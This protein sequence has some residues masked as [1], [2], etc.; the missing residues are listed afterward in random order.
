[1]LS[2]LF[3]IKRRKPLKDGSVPIFMR[4]SSHQE[5]VECSLRRST[6]PSQWVTAKG[7]VRNNTL[8]NKQLN[9]YLDQ[10]EFRI[11][12]I[13]RGLL[14]EGKQ[15]S[16]QEVMR[17]YRGVEQRRVRCCANFMKSTIPG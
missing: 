15:V 10:Q 13:E 6:M 8:V 12:D 3:F 16:V 4:V 9:E 1:M 14:A 2:I 11:Y 17:Q 5:Y 7:R